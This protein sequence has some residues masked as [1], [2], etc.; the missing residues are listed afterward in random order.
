MAPAPHAITDR[1]RRRP[2]PLEA[3]ADPRDRADR[4]DRRGQE[5]RGR[6]LLAERGALRASTPTRWATPCSTRA[7][8]ATGSSSGSAPA[9]LAPMPARPRRPA[10]DRPPGAGGDR[11]RRPGGAARPRGDPPPADAADLREGDRPRRSAGAGA[12]PSCSTRR[13]CSRR[14]GTTLCDRVVF[15]DAPREPRLARL[16]AQRGLDRR[17]VL[18]AREAAQW[19][20]DEKRGRADA[21]RRQRRAASNALRRRGR[22]RSG[23]H[24]SAAPPAPDRRAAVAGPAAPTAR[25][26]CHAL[27]AIVPTRFRRVPMSRGRPP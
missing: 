25:G 26:P 23:P 20:L 2:R 9:I 5:P 21:R 19:P 10:G 13:S 15:V 16:A 8:S 1:A 17:D 3:R 12:G 22:P 4:R 7:R 18:A 6:G 11:L 14:A 27:A 24:A